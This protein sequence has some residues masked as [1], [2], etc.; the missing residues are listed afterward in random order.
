ML[1]ICPVYCIDRDHVREPLLLLLLF[2]KKP[3][4]M[5]GPVY[6]RGAPYIAGDAGPGTVDGMAG[7]AGNGIRIPMPLII[8]R[9]ALPLDVVI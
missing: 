2:P 9:L 6:G 8:T 1:V 5:P 4:D 7:R 3:K